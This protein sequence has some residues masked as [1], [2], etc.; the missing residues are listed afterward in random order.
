MFSIGAGAAIIAAVLSFG[1]AGPAM[2]RAGAIAASLG[3]S[4][5]A[6]QRGR[7]TPDLDKLRRRAAI[8]NTLAVGFGL[9]AASAM[10]IARYI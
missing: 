9:L 3:A 6:T 4:S 10:A 7:L 1:V 5:D 8:A 2:V